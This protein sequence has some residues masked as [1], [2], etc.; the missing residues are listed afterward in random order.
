MFL[1]LVYLAALFL[2]TPLLLYRS[3]RQGKYRDGWGAKFFG[4]VPRLAPLPDGRRRVWFH[5]VSV[6]EVN[7]LKPIVAELEAER[8][9]WEFVVS[10]TSKTGFELARRLY[11]ARTSVFYCPLDFTWAVKTAFRRLRPNALV[12]VELELWPNLIAA[13]EKAGVPVAVVNGRIGDGSFRSYSRVRRLLAPTFGRLAAVVAQDELAAERF[14]ALT[15]FPERVSVSGS[16]KF[17][18]VETNRANA[19]TVRLARLAGIVP[20]D[21]VFLCGS[22]QD[23]EE[24]AA[25]ETF[26]RLRDE[27]PAL[28]LIIV[29]RHKERFEEVA[30]LLEKSGLPWTRRSALSDETPAA[31][32]A[33]ASRVLLVDAIG[34]LG[35]WW[36][37]ARIAFV[38]G[39][40][41]TRGGQ[42]MLEPAG[43]G[44]AVSFGPNTRNFRTIVEALLRADAAVVVADGDEMTAFVRRALVDDDF[45]ERLGTAARTLTL[46]N[47]GATKRTVATLVRL[48]DETADRRRSRPF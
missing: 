41:G 23:P 37:T 34:E 42:N 20:G 39:S 46:Q 40:W 32:N 15:P 43:Y 14:R 21:V 45:R 12:L 24:A 13:A 2:A 29:P 31:P 5:A 1:N 26:R 19:A 47:R 27:F 17:D 18:G 38:G 6:G 7:L 11:G 3:L 4:L 48:L 25:L 9:D 44:A 33:P 22:S 10:A 28:K 30:R 8:P 36:G 16:I 35:A